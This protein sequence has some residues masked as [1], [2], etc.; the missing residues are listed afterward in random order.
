MAIRK[1]ESTKPAQL[2]EQEL[3]ALREI[4]IAVNLKGL[5]NAWNYVTYKKPFSLYQGAARRVE[6]LSKKMMTGNASVFGLPLGIILRNTS[7]AAHNLSDEQYHHVAHVAGGLAVAGAMAGA[8][9]VAGPVIAGAIGAGLLGSV[10]GYGASA[11]AS[12]VVLHRPVFTLG[13]LATSSVVAAGVAVFST[14]VAAPA[15]LLVG[16][17]R[18]KA[19]LKGIKLTEDQLVAREVAFDR[20]SPLANYEQRQE[21]FARQVFSQLPKEKK[22]Q[23]YQT[24]KAEFEPAAAPAKKPAAPARKPKGPTQG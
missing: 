23:L 1:K 3:D 4:H 13:T 22:E 2:T 19:S 7:R 5:L 16:F 24:L 15:N 10:I 20:R 17:R 18:S 9:F 12:F 6:R 21:D 11:A 14:L 8:A